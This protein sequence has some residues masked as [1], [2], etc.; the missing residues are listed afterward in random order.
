MS[1]GW[2]LMNFRTIEK[3]FFVTFRQQKINPIKNNLKI[4]T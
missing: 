2:T 4:N 3:V 1:G